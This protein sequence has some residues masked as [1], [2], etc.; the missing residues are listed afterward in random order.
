[1]EF[2]CIL[3]PWWSFIVMD[4]TNDLVTSI[5]SCLNPNITV[6]CLSWMLR[7]SDTTKD[8]S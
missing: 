5:E 1:M 7:L 8:F 3:L 6:K 4:M 2:R